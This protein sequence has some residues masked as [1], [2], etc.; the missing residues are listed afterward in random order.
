MWG[1]LP[2]WIISL[3]LIVGAVSGAA[4]LDRRD[5]V[6]QP[7]EFAGHLD[8]FASLELPKLQPLMPDLSGP[9]D[10]TPALKA[11][12]EAYRADF[13][14]YDRAAKGDI[15]DNFD[16]LPAI[17]PIIDVA[18]SPGAALLAH[19]KSRPSRTKRSGPNWM[20]SACWAN[21]WCVRRSRARRPIRR[22]PWVITTPRW[23]WA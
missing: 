23:R 14:T 12:I 5:R 6:T 18:M 15:P 16:A 13:L 19:G 21:R 7:T 3:L 2:G 17:A 22:P 1:N 9:A 11:A 4:Y 20:P 10:A 8:N